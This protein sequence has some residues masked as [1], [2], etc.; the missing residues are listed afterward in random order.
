[1][2]LVDTLSQAPNPET[3]PDM[4]NNLFEVMTVSCISTAHLEELRKHAAKEEV[5]KT[6]STV[7][8]GG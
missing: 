1:M 2:Y 8:Q 4:E 5:L 3:S 6:L 7:I